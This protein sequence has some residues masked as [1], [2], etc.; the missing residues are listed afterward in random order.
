MTD[1]PDALAAALLSADPRTEL[2]DLLLTDPALLAVRQAAQRQLGAVRLEP[3]SAAA[4]LLL[5]ISGHPGLSAA[6]LAERTGLDVARPGRQLLDVGLV[7]S[8][9][10]ER[11][12]CW[13]RTT[14]G[15]QEAARLRS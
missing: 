5:A 4:V 10:F 13:A 11:S 3:G 14:S 9:R 6:E 12:D 15:A 8:S 2:A 7:T 1:E